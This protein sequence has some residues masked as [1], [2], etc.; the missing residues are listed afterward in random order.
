VVVETRYGKLQAKL[1]GKPAYD[2][3]FVYNIAA[4]VQRLQNRALSH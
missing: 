3:E 2:L 1:A 4:W